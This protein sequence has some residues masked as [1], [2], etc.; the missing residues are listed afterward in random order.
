MVCD[1]SI[2]QHAPKT[3]EDQRIPLQ[4]KCSQSDTEYIWFAVCYEPKKP[5]DDEVALRLTEHEKNMLEQCHFE[6]PI[7]DV[8]IAAKGHAYLQEESL[9][10]SCIALDTSVQGK[11]LAMCGSG[12]DAGVYLHLW[13][14]LKDEAEAQALHKVLKWRGEITGFTLLFNNYPIPSGYTEQRENQSTSVMLHD[15]K[16]ESHYSQAR[17]KSNFQCCNQQSD[18]SVVG[19]VGLQFALPL[20]SEMEAV[21]PITD[22]RVVFRANSTDPLLTAEQ[23]GAGWE[24]V[25]N[26]YF[27]N[28]DVVANGDTFSLNEANKMETQVNGT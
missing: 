18:I 2:A 8:R 7:L 23:V 4:A 15:L 1:Y 25:E 12:D 22:V 24:I 17:N 16:P 3:P 14:P 13:P 11:D 21:Q 5:L 19:S 26:L 6:E 28:G 9:G 20:P 10:S 27:G